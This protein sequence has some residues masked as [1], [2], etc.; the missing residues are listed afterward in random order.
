MFR[1]K[2]L[3]PEIDYT[4]R[5]V[6]ARLEILD[7]N[8]REFYDMADKE[9]EF[10]IEVRRHRQRRS[11]DANSYFH[12][13]VGKIAQRIGSSSAEVKNRML[14]LYGQMDTDGENKPIFMIVRDDIQVEKWEEIHLRAT[15]QTRVL[16]GILYRVYISIR[17]SHTYNTKEMSTLIDGTISEAK[18]AGLTEAE[19]IS[20][21]EAKI[22]REVYGIG[23]ER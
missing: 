1:A 22:L 4:T 5:R 12:V 18:D 2:L 19:I 13:L 15:E 16:N 23:V 21:K 11:L 10:D 8:Y 3:Q 14:S 20:T 9:K 7:G 17:G 6:I